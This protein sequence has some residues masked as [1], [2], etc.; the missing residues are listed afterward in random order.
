MVADEQVESGRLAFEG[1]RLLPLDSEVLKTR[2]RMSYNGAAMVTLVMDEEGALDGD[3]EVSLQG[4]IEETESEDLD[5]I[6]EFVAAA[7]SR[8][9]A[10]ERRDDAAVKEAA[11]TALRRVCN[12]TFGKKPPTSVHLVRFY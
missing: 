2:Q 1:R 11:R 4:L 7:V 5:T 9:P 3:P 12:K 8:L 10:K 6:V